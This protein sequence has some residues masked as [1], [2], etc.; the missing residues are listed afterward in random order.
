MHVPKT[1]ALGATGIVPPV[2]VINV[3]PA[4]AVSVPPQV[5]VA[6]GAAAIFRPVPIVVRLSVNDVIVADSKVLRLVKVMDKVVT[7]VWGT[8]VI[9]NALPTVTGDTR[10]VEL[11]ALYATPPKFPAGM[12]LV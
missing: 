4:V 10:S 1:V 6:A 11:L 12:E 3:E 2:K 8:D 5:V 9:V 7:P